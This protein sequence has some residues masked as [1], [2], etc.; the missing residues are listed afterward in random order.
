MPS[1]L[2]G[3]A[4]WQNG[5]AAEGPARQGAI[6]AQLFKCPG[7]VGDHLPAFSY[8]LVIDGSASGPLLKCFWHRCAVQELT[9]R[10]GPGQVRVIPLV[11]EGVDSLFNVGVRRLASG[12][13]EGAIL[14]MR[15]AI[16][17]HPRDKASH[18]KM[19]YIFLNSGRYE[20]AKWAFRRAGGLDMGDAEPFYGL[21]LV[22]MKAPNERYEAISYFQ[23]A[24]IRNQDHANA[25]Y[26]IALARYA[27]N[28]HDTGK[29]LERVLAIDPD[30]ADAYLLMGD[31]CANFRDDYDRAIVWYTK[32]LALRPDDARGHRQFGLACLQLENYDRILGTL[33]DF[34]R[35]HPDA[36]G[37][38]P[39]VAQALV[40]DDKL[41]MAM[42]LFSTY[43]ARI[44]SV[45]REVYNDIRPIASDEEARAFAQTSGDGRAVFLKQFWSSRD[46]DITTPVNERLLEHYRRVWYSRLSFSRTKEP[47]DRR[48]EV[49]LRFGEPDH[50]STSAMMNL[51]RDLEVQRVPPCAVVGDRSVDALG[52]DPSTE[53]GRGDAHE[54]TGAEASEAR[55]KVVEVLLRAAREEVDRLR[56]AVTHP[57]AHG[58]EHQEHG[59]IEGQDEQGHAH[60]G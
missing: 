12:D 47:W 45:E 17:Q 52:A 11:A 49:Y 19:G 32:Y 57:L 46:P 18:L 59:E 29:E 13:A 16:H 2:E 9:I 24:L 50:K 55:P 44:D 30:Y 22:H 3:L 34:V 10:R 25:R 60:V 33:L 31:W 4:D 21:G 41:D 23:K 51:S 27:M 14:P 8:E 58:V 20:G 28:E 53:E 48:G 56:T 26:Q 37:L 36:I 15:A 7:A 39:V 6:S 42:G 38:M 1:N 35:E 5:A 40:K 43:V 54:V